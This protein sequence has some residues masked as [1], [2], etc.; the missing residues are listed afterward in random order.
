MNNYYI[1]GLYILIFI[2]IIY[3]IYNFAFKKSSIESF[4][5][6]SE[7][8]EES[9]F[10]K[11]LNR[12]DFTEKNRPLDIKYPIIPQLEGTYK[13]NGNMKN[14][15]WKID[16]NGKLINI[17]GIYGTISLNPTKTKLN[18]NGYYPL[19]FT[20]KNNLQY[21]AFYNG[22][23][24]KMNINGTNYTILLIDDL[25]DIP[26]KLSNINAYIGTIED[27]NNIQYYI[28]KEGFLISTTNNR[29]IAQLKY[30]SA[31]PPYKDTDGKYTFNIEYIDIGLQN[32]FGRDLKQAVLSRTN[33]NI[34]NN[35]NIVTTYIKV[36]VVASP[37]PSS[38]VFGFTELKPPVLKGC[39][40]T[41]TLSY[42]EH[43]C[44]N[45]SYYIINYDSLLCIGIGTDGKTLVMQPVDK[46]NAKQV[47]VPRQYR[48]DDR[49]NNYD[50]EW[51]K[52][53]MQQEK[54]KRDDD[55]EKWNTITQSKIAQWM[56]PTNIY[57][58]TASSYI[59]QD[60]IDYRILNNNGDFLLENSTTGS[61]V[62]GKFNS[63]TTKLD[64][65]IIA[66]EITTNKRNGYDFDKP[67]FTNI[68]QTC[69]YNCKD[70][71][72]KL[73]AFLEMDPLFSINKNKCD[74]NNGCASKIID[75]PCQKYDS[76]CSNVPI[77]ETV[78]TYG[79]CSG[80]I[81]LYEHPNYTGISYDIDVNKSLGEARGKYPAGTAGIVP[82]TA[83]PW[84]GL[85]NDAASS[86][87]VPKGTSITLYE[88]ANYGGISKTFTENEPDLAWAWTQTGTNFRSG[89][90]TYRGF[91]NLT[92]SYKSRCF[93]AEKVIKTEIKDTGKT[94]KVCSPK[95]CVDN[96]PPIPCPEYTCLDNRNKKF[97]G[98]Y[99]SIVCND[100][101]E[102]YD[103]MSRFRF[104]GNLLEL[105][106]RVKDKYNSLAVDNRQYIQTD[107]NECLISY[108]KANTTD[109]I[110]KRMWYFIPA[111]EIDRILP[112]L[113]QRKR[114]DALEEK[115][116]TNVKNFQA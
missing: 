48:L 1:G 56:L 43:I 51:C 98:N 44:I 6:I 32:L 69:A 58:N 34:Y 100:K 108:T 110:R 2:V 3:W 20:N 9:I 71:K 103:K 104:E 39:S 101:T 33:L 89:T 68:S 13:G 115:I 18:A 107:G 66:K 49:Y 14:T 64:L 28:S 5:Q 112:K 63:I 78:K 4:E 55:Y 90:P 11:S 16:K 8:Q 81:Q 93:A 30:T 25:T 114:N 102:N 57:K 76:N 37:I 94:K 106:T 19:I 79:K 53:D 62:K 41:G 47:W 92:S 40:N 50:N 73:D 83:N 85:F 67:I 26:M 95:F 54:E 65:S 75:P 87:K 52:I 15:Y 116:N 60:K 105:V 72:S 82:G 21:P 12:N 24:F 80:K 97:S 7:Y 109:T 38:S 35:S 84:I 45:R 46:N 23:K 29:P 70:S 10:L 113:I 99:Q 96:P 42:Y 22:S 111:N 31:G 36:A 74:E 86:I 88:H 27:D 59:L 77:Y 17:Y 61:F 91:D